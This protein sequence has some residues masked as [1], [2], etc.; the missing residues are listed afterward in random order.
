MGIWVTLKPDFRIK[1]PRFDKNI[2]KRWSYIAW[3][4]HL[5]CDRIL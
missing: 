3:P 5:C 2:K 1:P 4:F